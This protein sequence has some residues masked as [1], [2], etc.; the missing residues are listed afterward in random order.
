MTIES[1]GRRADAHVA[2]PGARPAPATELTKFLDPLRIP[3]VIEATGMFQHGRLEITAQATK[4]RLHSELPVTSVWAYEGHFP[5]PTIEVRRGERLRVA[6]RNA[7]SG[8]F[9]MAAVEPQNLTP[10]PGRDGA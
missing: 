8:A 2:E 9:P 10:G 7:V 1:T 4:V 5:G 6:W 3:P